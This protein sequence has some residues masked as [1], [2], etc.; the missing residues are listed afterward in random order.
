M[1]ATDDDKRLL[2]TYLPTSINYNFPFLI[3]ANFLTDAGRQNI[4]LDL[5][6]NQWLFNQ[7]PFKTCKFTWVI[8]D[9]IIFS[10]FY[11]K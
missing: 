3:N 9:G 11:N 4:H 8:Y 2:F 6:W 5:E 10:I 7:I 1:K